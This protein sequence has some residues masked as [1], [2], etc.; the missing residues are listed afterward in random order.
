MDGWS[1][2]RMV[3]HGGRWYE[4]LADGVP[5]HGLLDLSS[6]IS[7]YG[8]GPRARLQWSGLLEQLDRY[9]DPD[10]HALLGAITTHYGVSED[11]VTLTAGAA[12]AFDLLY[13]ALAPA[14]VAVLIPAFSEYV[15]RAKAWRIPIIR[16]R[17]LKD[18]PQGPGLLMLANPANPTGN[19]LS[20][21]Q[22]DAW[23]IQARI[24]GWTTV[25]DE[26]FLEFLPNWRALSQMKRTSE[27][28]DVWVV[29]SLTKFYGLAALR[30]GFV[31]SRS[32]IQRQLH[33]YQVP[34]QVS[35]VAAA[36]A[37]AALRDQAYFSATREQII[38]DRTHLIAELSKRAVILGE[39][40]ANFI[41]AAPTDMTVGCLV[42]GLQ[43]RGILVRDARSFEGLTVPAV[44]VAVKRPRD[45]ARLLLAWDGV[46]TNCK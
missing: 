24:Q 46:G 21:D 19:L 18:L 14:K 42:D 22:L 34:W 5:S 38:R 37:A 41:L 31:V 32:K 2:R 8:P 35:W 3:V 39:S 16:V 15:Q 17:T 40:A 7:P 23:R 1:V 28:D 9:P 27:D 36:V 45:H 29:Q 26:A 12:E 30:I 25:V 43:S 4:A 6:S 44:R 13:R 33:R 10:Y 20:P 11:Q